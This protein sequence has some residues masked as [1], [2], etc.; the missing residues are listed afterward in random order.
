MAEHDPQT[1]HCCVPFQNH[2]KK[3]SKLNE[4]NKAAENISSGA[5]K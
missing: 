5:N 4:R 2:E 3:K 1:L